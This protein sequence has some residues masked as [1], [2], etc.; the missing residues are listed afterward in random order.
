MKKGIIS[1]TADINGAKLIFLDGHN[2]PGFS[3]GPIVYRDFNKSDLVF[4]LAGVV[5]GFL[6]ETTPVLKPKEIEPTQVTREDIAKGLILRKKDQWY[7]LTETEDAVQLNT[8]IVRGFA[9][10][11]VLDL[12]RKH[13]IG[14]IMPG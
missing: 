1:G 4:K 11:P 12:I 3:G 6:P 2:N 7:K 9:I 13:P 8:G 5:S 14:P 10:E